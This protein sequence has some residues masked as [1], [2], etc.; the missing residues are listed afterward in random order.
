M[1]DVYMV[2]F[3]WSTQD[4]SAVEAELFDTYEKAYGRYQE[5]ITNEKDPELSWVGAEAVDENGNIK[6]GY[7]FGEHDDGLV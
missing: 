1:R 6:D 7:D 4:D 3:D 5:I 2:L